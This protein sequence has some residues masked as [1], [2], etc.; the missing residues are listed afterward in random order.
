MLDMRQ[1]LGFEIW[2]VAAEGIVDTHMLGLSKM[3]FIVLG[4]SAAFPCELVYLH[5]FDFSVLS[6]IAPLSL[7]A[8][9]ARKMFFGAVRCKYTSHRILNASSDVCDGC[10]ARI[11]ILALG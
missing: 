4:S 11:G 6:R 7:D 3:T 2:A 10:M 1:C 5:I 8:C 9:L